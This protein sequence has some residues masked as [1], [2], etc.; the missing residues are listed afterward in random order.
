MQHGM[1]IPLSQSYLN[2][3]ASRCYKIYNLLWKDAKADFWNML[4]EG[5]ADRFG[6]FQ[7]E[8][9][10]FESSEVCDFAANVGLYTHDQYMKRVAAGRRLK[11]E[12]MTSSSLKK[13]ISTKRDIQKFT[14]PFRRIFKRSDKHN[15]EE[16]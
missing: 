7:H 6:W 12:N 1:Y 11:T 9:S 2:L 4:H 3:S 10:D 13:R 15:G 14:N 5:Y 8:A 16:K